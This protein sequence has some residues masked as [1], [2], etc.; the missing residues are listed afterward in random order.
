MPQVWEWMRHASAFVPR[1][2]VALSRSLRY[3]LLKL[4]IDVVSAMMVI[5]DVVVKTKIVLVFK[6]EGVG[7]LGV[8]L[9]RRVVYS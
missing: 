7:V 9:C 1:M 4:L 8:G 5:V 2:P 3:V 6:Y